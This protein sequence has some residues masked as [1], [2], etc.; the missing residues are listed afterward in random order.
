MRSTR[1]A[2]ALLS[3]ALALG[4]CTDPHTHP[5]RMGAGR[6]GPRRGGT[7]R[8]AMD[9]DVG[10]ADPALTPDTTAMIAT[11]LL[12][13]CLVDYAASGTAD[14]VPALAERWEVSSDGLAYTFH[15][16]PSGRFGNGRAV[17]SQDFAWSWERMLDPHRRP[18]PGAENYRLIDGYDEY[19]A[20]RA[21]HLR[22]L[23]TP[24]ARTLVVRLSQ[25]DRTFLHALALRFAAAVPRE[26]VEAI[27]DERFGAEGVGA[28]PF[29]IERWEPGFRIVFRRNPY[30]WNAPR[31][32]VDRVIFEVSIARHLQF[33]RFLAGELELAHNYSL[34]TA[35][36]LWIKR[37]PAW[38]PYVTSTPVPSVG[39]FMMNTEM[40]PFDNVHVRRAV[41]FAID[42]DALCRARN[43]RIQPAWGLYPPSIPGHR[44]ALPNAQRFDLDE[45]RREMRL[46]GLPDGYPDEV[47]LWIGEGESGLVY[48]QLIQADLARIGLRMRIKQASGSVYY[49]SLGQRHTVPMGFT[50]WQMDF[51]DPSNF[52][53]PSFHSRAIQPENSSNYAFYRNAELDRLLDRGHVEPD[54]ARR[55]GLYQEAEQMLLRD[56]PWA[57]L[58]NAVELTAVQPYVRQWSLHPVWNYFPVDVWLD[59][60]TQAWR[61]ARR[62]LA[63][64]LGPLARLSTPLPGVSP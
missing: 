55:I 56:A 52:I 47:E 57:F 21:A 49:S 31:P 6:H 11:R 25:P 2:E 62:D 63:R 36:Y 59:L 18:S 4:A 28:G 61:A 1:G 39:A 54:D 10:T 53:E 43:Y 38:R 51:P 23:S 48:G 30:Y 14:V 7:F 13:E 58:Y 32:W 60:P 3:I 12:H 15:L 46:A 64:A 17:T 41:A 20:G 19:R 29:V 8:F 40:R 34:S 22:G 27:G 24:D 9:G 35:D 5:A 16:R 33:M 42:R 26:V 44:D 50:G 45:A 37:Q